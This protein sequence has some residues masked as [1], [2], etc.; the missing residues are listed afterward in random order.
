MARA[1]GSRAQM[2]LAFETVYGTAPASGYIQMP[3]ATSGL[4]QEQPLIDNE[5]LGYG[6]DP[7]A[8]SRDAINVDGDVVVPVDLVGIGHW[9][10]ALF[11]APDTTGTTPKVHT[12]ESGNYA[13]PSMSI[14]I[15]HPEVPRFEMFSGVRANSLRIEATRRGLLQ[16]TVGLIGQGMAPNSA[17]QAGTPSTF[18]LT[19]FGHFNC[20]I[21]RNGSA[22]GNIVQADFTYSNNLDRVETIRADGKIDGADPTIASLGGQIRARFADTVLLD[23]AIA[24]GACELAFTWTISAN[25][26]LSITAHSV[27]LPVP[28]RP[29]QGPGGVEATFDWQAALATSPARMCTAVLTNTV[30]SYA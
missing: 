19:R 7:L 18:A 16:A 6:R 2:A 11:G 13:L 17:T 3:F 8:P 21:S 23:Q 4:G 15:G 22:L 20:A 30:A 29:V 14:E 26:S 12:Y 10:K 9:L 28:K 25:A 27:F 5:L 24:G 1:Y